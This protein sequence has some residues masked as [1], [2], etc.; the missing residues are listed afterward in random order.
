MYEVHDGQ[1]TFDSSQ[2]MSHFESEI[3]KVLVPLVKTT[4][5]KAIYDGQCAQQTGG[6]QCKCKK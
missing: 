1:P 2:D 6:D 4:K 3:I 5:G